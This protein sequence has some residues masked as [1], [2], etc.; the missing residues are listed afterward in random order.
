MT[1][2]LS[3]LDRLRIE[4]AVWALDQRLYDLPT[5]SRVAKRREVR[6]N[7]LGAANDIG[8]G[9]AL[10]RL[11]S[12]R[13]LAAEYRSAEFGDGPRP[14]WYA[15]GFFLLTG[16]LIFTS[17]LSEAA[18][19]FRDGILAVNAH[20]TGTFTWPGIDFLQSRVTYTFVDG[21]A[22]SVGGA[23]TPLAWALWIVAF[24]LIGRLWRVVPLRRRRRAG[25][26]ASR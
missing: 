1:S 8:A 10:S 3:W 17:I 19:A 11:G 23:W 4:R 12:S 25:E 16:Q 24:V 5:K 21:K 13:E 20:A 15:A 18:F 7:L 22:T 9:A 2:T 26:A 14:L 6:A